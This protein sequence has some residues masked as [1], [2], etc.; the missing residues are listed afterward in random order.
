MD[1]NVK[2]VTKVCKSCGKEMPIDVFP[3]NKNSH[4]GHSNL[5]RECL[6]AS[7][8]AANKKRHSNNPERPLARFTPRQLMEELRLRGYDGELTYVQRIKLSTL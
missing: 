8:S 3:K 2:P 7:K 6:S 1:E 4:D 5:C